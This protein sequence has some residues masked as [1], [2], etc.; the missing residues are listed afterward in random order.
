MKRWYLIAAIF[1]TVALVAVDASAQADAPLFDYE[2]KAK[3]Q[4]DQGQPVLVLRAREFIS[5]GTVT[6]ER[7]DGDKRTTKIGKLK[8]GQEKRISFKQPRNS[9]YD[10]K[11]SVSGK[12]QF[13]QTMDQ[14][15]TT[16]TAW[17]DPIK[18]QV[19]PETVK[20]G[21]GRL[22]LRSNVPLAK[23]DIEVFDKKGNKI[24]E[25]TQQI[26]GKNGDLPITW[27]SSSPEVG[28]I[29]LRATDMADFWSAVLLEPFWVDIPHREVVFH[30]GKA[31]W[32][33]TETPKLQET[34][35]AV[36]QAI[37]AHK[38]KGLQMQLYIAGYTDTVGGAA[39]NNQLSTSRARAIAGW[40]RK[41]G[42]SLPIF[43]QGF[44][45]S[46]LAVQ[47][48]DNTPEARN[49]R[50]LYILGNATPPTSGQIPRRNWKKL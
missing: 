28:A 35:Q 27:D 1:L 42:V 36:N 32:D 47:T 18:L 26:G 39:D 11:I 19:K 41:A 16:Q 9:A 34:L 10:W 37:E 31:T 6:M 30:F 22:T 48:P 29:R 4:T 50:A 33:D 49:R 40:F 15:F 2:V 45:E 12:S 8:P 5:S 43:Y 25:R 17:V 13:N 23:V 46:V 38:H 3:V 7:S 21:E 44:G 14:E 20:V 24:A